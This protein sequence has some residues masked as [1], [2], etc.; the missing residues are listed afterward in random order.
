MDS[1]VNKSTAGVKADA[2]PLRSAINR[3]NSVMRSARTFLHACLA[4]KLPLVLIL[5][6]YSGSLA[7]AAER[8]RLE[9][10]SGHLMP[11]LRVAMAVDQGLVASS[12][13]TGAI[14]AWNLR[15]GRSKLL[16]ASTPDLRGGHSSLVLNGA[17]DWVASVAFGNGRLGVQRLSSG[18]D[19]TPAHVPPIHRLVLSDDGRH[20][21]ALTRDGVLIRPDPRDWSLARGWV[22]ADGSCRLPPE[23]QPGDPYGNTDLLFSQDGNELVSVNGQGRVAWLDAQSGCVRRTLDLGGG[24]NYA[25]LA[26]NT[27]AGWV[28][29]SDYRTVTVR[30]LNGSGTPLVFPGS[31]GMRRLALNREG[32]ALHT[33]TSDG[34]VRLHTLADGSTQTWSFPEGATALA[35]DPDNGQLAVGLFSG[36]VVINSLRKG[37]TQRLTGA[38][39]LPTQLARDGD[40][41]LLVRTD[42]FVLRVDPT[43][44]LRRRLVQAQ[45]GEQLNMSA[46]GQWVWRVHSAGGAQAYQMGSQ[47]QLALPAT[48]PMNMWASTVAPSGR[49]IAVSFGNEMRLYEVSSGRH[50]R[51]GSLPHPATQIGFSPDGRWLVA[52]GEAATLQLFDLVAQKSWNLAEAAGAAAFAFSADSTELAIGGAD[53]GIRLVTLSGMASRYLRMRGS[54]A[55]V[56]SLAFSPNGQRLAASRGGGGVE[57]LNIGVSAEVKALEAINGDV[58]SLVFLDDVLVAGAGASGEIKLWHGDTA[59][60]SMFFTKFNGW[61]T[62]APDGRFDSTD[63]ERPG[64]VAWVMPDAPLR[65]LPP[66]I[67]MRDFL[68]PKLLPRLLACRRAQST[69]PGACDAAFADVPD[70]AQLNR[71]QPEIRVTSIRRGATPDEAIV[72]VEARAGR[73]GDQVSGERW[74]EA[75][76]VHLLRD[77][78]LVGRWPDLEERPAQRQDWR[79]ATQVTGGK[80]FDWVARDFRVRLPTA[81][82]SKVSFSA[83][84]F[85]EDRV[86]S[87]AAP[88][89]SIPIASGNAKPR[90][91]VIT[92]GANDY[93]AASRRLSYAVADAQAM[94]SA[95]RQ[96]DGFEIVPI[97]LRS[98][99]PRRT[100]TATKSTLTA[101]LARLGGKSAPLPRSVK[102]DN[103]GRATPDDLVVL[104]FSGHGH[105]Q[106]N[107]SFYLVTSDSGPA[108]TQEPGQGLPPYALKKL[109][110]A[111]ELSAALGPVDAGRIVVIIDAC[112]AAASVEQPGYKPGPMGDR[113]LGQLAYDKGMQILAASQADNV[114]IESAKV[115]HGLLTYALIREGLMKA[116]DG[117]H[118]AN[119]DG[120][121]KLTLTEWLQFGEQRTPLLYDEIREGRLRAVYGGS[122]AELVGKN[123]IA[124]PAFRSMMV[125]QQQVPSFFDY[126]RGDADVLLP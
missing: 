41:G 56:T 61:V 8:P 12:D 37:T 104:M 81:S 16:S 115:R 65:P 15:T 83:Y 121:G 93:D 1:H 103:L 42:R 111:E 38:V 45:E 39:V 33:M 51:L 7:S 55:R 86:K 43:R 24:K 122:S 78:Q 102:A 108:I 119:L 73:E 71:V 5:S 11:V 58:A 105:A 4:A 2:A 35:V 32:S 85:N 6:A 80:T 46:D 66:E 19:L 82:R 36:D 100:W 72:T 118:R 20:L 9:V 90:A 87:E 114:A 120:D 49:H 22:P 92:V 21:A 62:V 26:L 50:V 34:T 79:A 96:L 123:T 17:A 94:A 60:A 54:G 117:V 112:H 47:V 125:R 3:P 25:G 95:L 59:L 63:L 67:F 28:A 27:A 13:L 106:P 89:V 126:K 52:A 91:F 76:D 107:G 110:S 84:A 70:L 113:G 101:V 116:S 57:L 23:E 99:G 74:S 97:N 109:I 29:L 77:G 69:R 75:Y 30:R 31:D 18:A 68:E 44:G 98:V 53:G 124:S 88:P 64:A 10:Q 14:R 40:G 48:V